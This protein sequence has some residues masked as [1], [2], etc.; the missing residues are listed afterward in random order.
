MT[1]EVI[2]WQKVT[3]NLTSRTVIVL[4]KLM[5]L[6]FNTL[7]AIQ[8]HG[9]ALNQNVSV[10]CLSCHSIRTSLPCAALMTWKETDLNWEA[11][12]PESQHQRLPD[13]G[14]TGSAHRVMADNMLD[15]VGGKYQ[16]QPDE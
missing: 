15:Q 12:F 9:N 2:E 13:W 5:L 11:K 10:S 1:Q 6:A 14:T 8:K 7:E 3:E 4:A 16:D